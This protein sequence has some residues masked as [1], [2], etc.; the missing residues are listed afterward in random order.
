MAFTRVGG[1]AVFAIYL[2][3]SL[4]YTGSVGM[5]LYKDLAQSEMSRLN[6]LRLFSYGL[7]GGG[8]VLLTGSCVFFM[9]KRPAF[10]AALPEKVLTQQSVA[11]SEMAE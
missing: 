6:F 7:A 4:G 9:R 2:A 5:Q 10:P 11:T 8:A 1:T 3:D